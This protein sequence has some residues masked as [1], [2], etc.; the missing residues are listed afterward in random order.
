MKSEKWKVKSEK[1]KVKS[2]KWKWM[3]R[4]NEWKERKKKERNIPNGSMWAWKCP[5]RLYAVR[6]FWTS[7]IVLWASISGTDVVVW[8]KEL[9]LF[10]KNSFHELCTLEGSNFHASYCA[11]TYDGARTSCANC[12]N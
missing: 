7:T 9:F 5:N 11:L 3:K 10:E 2:E 6:I 1:W 4:E 8:S 12:F